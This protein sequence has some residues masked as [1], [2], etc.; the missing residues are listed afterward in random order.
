MYGLGQQ[1][2][3]QHGI[4][5]YSVIG[6]GFHRGFGAAIVVTMLTWAP[7]A[8]AHTASA[9]HG[10]VAPSRPA[11]DQNDLLWQRFLAAVDEFRACISDYAAANRAAAESHRQAADDA[12]QQWN[13]FVRTRLNVPEDFP[14][15]PH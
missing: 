12:V 7:A 11:D 5:Q 13:E 1:G 15:P 4:R 2:I 8:V 6:R 14:W 9:D 10:C 3:R